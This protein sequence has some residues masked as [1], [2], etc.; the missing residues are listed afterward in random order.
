[1]SKS[2]EI[3]KPLNCYETIDELPIKAWFDIHDT[4]DYRLLLKEPKEINSEEFH[5]LFEK[6]ENLYN[7]YIARFGLSEEFLD[8]LNQQIE[9]ANYR[10][11]FIIT[12]Q[13]YFRTMI[14]VR[15]EVLKSNRK[16]TKTFELEMLL[17]KM[18]KY[19]GFKLE[20][21]DLTVVQYY[22]YLTNVK[23]G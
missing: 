6:W 13:R 5:Q 20:S 18:S 21:R 12:G 22:S 3:S 11:E 16:D 19:Y 4:G 1:M 7:Q 10:A 2:E 9:I 23:N 15:E 14:R 17:A 8:D